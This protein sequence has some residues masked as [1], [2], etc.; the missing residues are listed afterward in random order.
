MTDRRPTKVIAEAGV[1][2][3]GSLER[4]LAMVDAAAQ[5]GATVGEIC[6]VLKRVFGEYQATTGITE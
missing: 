6:G 5:A 2:H 3:N 1:N 4:A